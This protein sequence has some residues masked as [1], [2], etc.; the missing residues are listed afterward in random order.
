MNT[1]WNWNFINKITEAT[2]FINKITEGPWHRLARAETM[3]GTGYCQVLIMV[4]PHSDGFISF[5]FS[6]YSAM[7]FHKTTF[8][9]YPRSL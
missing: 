3:K 5:I 9:T 6:E 8:K 7:T 2:F 1:N 4:L